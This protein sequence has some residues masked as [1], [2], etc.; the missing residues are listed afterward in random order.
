[1]PCEAP[2]AVTAEAQVLGYKWFMDVVGKQPPFGVRIYKVGDLVAIESV[3]EGPEIYSIADR[4]E[5]LAR[6]FGF[7]T[8]ANEPRVDRDGFMFNG[9]IYNDSD[10]E[11]MF[12]LSGRAPRDL[13]IITIT[14]NHDFIYDYSD[15]WYPYRADKVSLKEIVILLTILAGSG[16]TPHDGYY[17]VRL[18]HFKQAEH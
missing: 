17:A 8:Y 4:F 12:T 9:S 3:I 6:L 10:V 5:N 11:Y 13:D 2:C 7:M 16:L 18:S 15:P 1:M 14:R